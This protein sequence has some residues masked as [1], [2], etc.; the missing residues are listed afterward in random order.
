MDDYH[1][2]C[3][4]AVHEAVAVLFE[5]LPPAPHLVITSREDPPLPLP[6]LRARHQLSEV[7]AADLGFSVEEAATFLGAGIGLRLERSTW[8]RWSSR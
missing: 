4:Q 1:L 8:R 2:V 6:R 7:R 3:A 5:H